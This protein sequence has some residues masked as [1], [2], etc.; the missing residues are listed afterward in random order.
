MC[1]YP[2][3]LV[4]ELRYIRITRFI[5]TGDFAHEAIFYLV[6][7]SILYSHFASTTLK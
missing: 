1:S 7:Y 6:R 5:M 3:T 4:L 2:K